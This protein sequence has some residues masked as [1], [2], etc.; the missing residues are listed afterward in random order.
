MKFTI[1]WLKEHL[2]YNASINELSETLTRVGLEVEEIFNPAENL[3]D[4]YTAKIDTVEKHPDADKLNLL[5]VDTGKEKLQIVCGAPNVKPGLIGILANVGVVIPCYNEKLKVGKIRG[6]ESF[7]MLCSEKEL[8]LGDDHNGII[9]LPA[10]TQIGVNV[11]EVLDIDPVIEI[12]ITPNRAECLGVRGIARDLA[13]AGFGKLKPFKVSQ[14]KATISSP[15]NV[16]MSLEG[17]NT[18]NCPIYT[19]RYIKGV[20]NKAET[21][22]YIRD[23]LTA[24]GLKTISPLVDITNYINYDL[25]RPM[26]VFDADKLTGDINIRMA[27]KDE[28]FTALDEQTYKLDNKMLGICDDEGVQCLAGIVGGLSKGCSSDT[29][30]VFLECAHFAPENIARS[31]RKLQLDSDSRYRYERWVDPNSTTTGSKIATKMILDI[32]GGEASDIIIAGEEPKNERK[33]SLRVNRIKELIGLDVTKE[34]I[35]EI[36]EKLEFKLTD[37]GDVIE[38]ISPTFRGDIT[39]EEDLVEEVVRM[40]GLDEIKPVSLP[41]ST[42]PKQTLSPKQR[43]VI[44]TKRELASRGMYETVTWS[45]TNSKFG[46]LFRTADD[47]VLLSNPISSDL[48]EMRPSILPNLLI[49]VKNNIARNYANTALF[50]VGPIFHGRKPGEQQ[51]VATGVRSANTSKKDWSGAIRSVDVFDAKAD[52]LAAIAA[53]NGPAANAQIT[54]D[55]PKYYHPGR[56]GCFRLGKNVLAYFGEIHPSILK[57]M[58]IKET[59]VAFETFLDNIPAPRT[60]NGKTKKLLIPSQ[61]QPLDKDLAFIVDSKTEAG[62]II[63]AAKGADKEHV[64][65]VRVFDI[66]EG[67]NLGENKKSVAIAVTFQPTDKTFT[68]K[69]IELLMNKVVLSVSKKTGG[70]LRS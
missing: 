67:T 45:F 32:C 57:K 9:E 51:V 19:G 65:D 58:G 26:H 70:E 35:I 55:A 23:R 12:A 20:N 11:S 37:K 2:D 66:Y 50:E 3:K 7:G 18:V 56:S 16:K 39:I 36:L 33:A 25:A 34:K 68:D 8:G 40:I 43:A 21:P 10:N 41:V 53:A 15:I 6:V 48:D 61:F 62:T 44:T 29:V 59:I 63:S 52:A 46:E 17:N 28:E 38:A 60:K 4:F 22:K 1:S 54:A 49:G 47:I 24:I 42:L 5:S 30:N 64:T 13:A 14:T 69:D 31:G 27:E